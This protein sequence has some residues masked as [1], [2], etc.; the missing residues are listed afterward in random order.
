MLF[1]V[2]DKFIVNSG[3]FIEKCTEPQNPNIPHHLAGSSPNGKIVNKILSFLGIK[4]V[5]R[6]NKNNDS[7]EGKKRSH[8]KSEPQRLIM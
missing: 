7:N 6:I 3:L 2:E 1:K 5:D 4:M 8:N